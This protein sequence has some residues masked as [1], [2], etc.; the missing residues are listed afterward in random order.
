MSLR[1]AG[2]TPAKFEYTEGKFQCSWVFTQDA[3]EEELL[4]L[5]SSLLAFMSSRGYKAPGEPQ[6]EPVEGFTGGVIYADPE[7]VLEPVGSAQDLPVELVTDE[8]E[9]PG[10]SWAEFMA[11]PREIEPPKMG[12]EG[13]A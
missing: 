2:K 11:N 6:E 1:L 7:L 12:E 5:A 13:A 4:D 8:P 10:I 9:V 3:T